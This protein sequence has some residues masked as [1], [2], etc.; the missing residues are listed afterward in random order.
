MT[1]SEYAKVVDTRT[2]MDALVRHAA[3]VQSGM[4]IKPSNIAFNTLR[5]HGKALL[6]EWHYAA[7]PR[8][9]GS[10]ALLADHLHVAL[11]AFAKEAGLTE[12]GIVNVISNVS[13]HLSLHFDPSLIQSE[14]KNKHR[15]MHEVAGIT[16]VAGRQR[17]GA[18]HSAATRKAECMEKLVKA[19]ETALAGGRKLSVEQLASAAGVSRSYAYRS[20][21][22]CQQICLSRCRVEKEDTPTVVPK[23]SG[24]EAGTPVTAPSP[25]VDAPVTYRKEVGVAWSVEDDGTVLERHQAWLEEMLV[26]RWSEKEDGDSAEVERHQAWLQDE[27]VRG[28]LPGDCGDPE[29]YL[30]A[31]LRPAS[32]DITI[33]VSD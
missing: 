30:S 20:L 25:A 5:E 18:A 11:E 1:L 17:V 16:S 26:S 33:L 27:Y 8:L 9:K 32:R 24:G 2:T 4:G 14:R 15:L 21:A 7:D 28:V 22:E 6:R 23:K 12:K 3:E 29:V 10:R 19:Y 31:H 13:G